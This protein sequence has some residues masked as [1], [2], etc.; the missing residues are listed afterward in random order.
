MKRFD[1]YG[2]KARLTRLA[3]SAWPVWQGGLTLL[4]LAGIAS[5]P[6]QAQRASLLLQ[7]EATLAGR[8]WQLGQVAQV[9]ADSAALQQQLQQLVL[10]RLP[11]PGNVAQLHRN[12]LEHTLRSTLALPGL[13]LEWQGAAT[14]SLRA[15]QQTVAGERLREVAQQGLQQL[16]QQRKI[17]SQLSLLSLSQD[18]VLPV[19]QLEIRLRPLQQEA[20]AKRMAVWLDLWV[21]GELYR[22]HSLLFELQT[23][24]A[25]ADS[26]PPG[27]V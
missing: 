7:A 22:S 1:R 11:L 18:V 5:A 19:G 27:G 2:R 25:L 6:A 17:D 4:L 3:L 8:Q 10:G 14:L 15:A 21:D 9:Q 24:P 16:L 20:L 13:Q 23:P 12:Q 26:A